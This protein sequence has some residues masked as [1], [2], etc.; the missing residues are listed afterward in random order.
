MDRCWDLS[1]HGRRIGQE[2]PGR[3]KL[4]LLVLLTA[5]YK[6]QWRL[7]KSDIHFW[8][9]G[10]PKN[11]PQDRFSII[12]HMVAYGSNAPQTS[13]I[14]RPQTVI[15]SVLWLISNGCLVAETW[16]FQVLG[17]CGA[18]KLSLHSV[19]MLVQ[20]TM[21]KLGANQNTWFTWRKVPCERM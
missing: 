13:T 18:P 1:C 12:G 10:A 14:C 19:Y 21:F 2:H 9:S 16:S 4:G 7:L 6:V 11:E 8:F 3:L 5:L 17:L 15:K 20:Q